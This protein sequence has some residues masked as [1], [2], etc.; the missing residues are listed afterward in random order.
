M[1]QNYTQCA[2]GYY[3]VAIVNSR[4]KWN[5]N[6]ESFS[7]GI[8][9]ASL[10]SIGHNEKIFVNVTLNNDKLYKHGRLIA[11]S[12]HDACLHT[13]LIDKNYF[14]NFRCHKSATAGTNT[15]NTMQ[16]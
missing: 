13:T 8:S 9:F 1:T 12:K 14:S 2:I 11:I 6:V 10:L 5:F 7:D 16:L 3:R 15:T 4:Q